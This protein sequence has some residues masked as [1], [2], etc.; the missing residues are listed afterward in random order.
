MRQFTSA[1]LARDNH[2]Q[3][4]RTDLLEAPMWWHRQGLTETATG[5]GRKLN[6]GLKIHFNGR[7]YR[8]YVTC[9]SNNGTVWF[10]SKGQR[11]IVG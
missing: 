1:D 10:T 8:L 5:Y 3:A 9:F 4:D 11:Y 6:S 7:L 2:I